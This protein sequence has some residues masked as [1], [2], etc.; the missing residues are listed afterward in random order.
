MPF[1]D[2]LHFR[3]RDYTPPARVYVH[4][5]AEDVRVR[6]FPEND[7]YVAA[8]HGAYRYFEKTIYHNKKFDLSKFAYII[9]AVWANIPEGHPHS[10]GDISKMID[11][12]GFHDFDREAID[13]QWRMQNPSVFSATLNGTK[14]VRIG[15]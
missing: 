10:T 3:E 7:D 11:L 6:W 8:V 1:K 14:P 15:W 12:F 5:T 2:V 13:E 4:H 9:G